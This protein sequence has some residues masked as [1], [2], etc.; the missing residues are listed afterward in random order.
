MSELE[1]SGL[2]VEFNKV[3]WQ[4]KGSLIH[5]CIIGSAQ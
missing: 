3:W 4:H 5:L 2:E 1:V